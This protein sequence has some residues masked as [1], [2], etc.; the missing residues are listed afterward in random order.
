MRH[1][2]DLFPSTTPK[3]GWCSCAL[4]CRRT[5]RRYY[6][7]LALGIGDE[8]RSKAGNRAGQSAR[9]QLP[10]F[11][12]C[13][14]SGRVLFG[15]YD[16]AEGRDP[17]QNWMYRRALGIGFP[18]DR[19]QADGEAPSCRASRN[20]APTGW[21]SATSGG[22]WG[23][24]AA[25]RLHRRGPD[26]AGIDPLVFRGIDIARSLWPDENCGCHADAVIVQAG[27]VG[28]AVHGARSR[29][30]RRAKS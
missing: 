26:R 5:G 24:T 11:W 17:F 16:R 20:Q 28:K 9:M 12:R 18:H 27:S 4:P 13:R 6:I 22:C 29:S 14:G 7:S 19:L 21:C 10:R 25:A 1:A 8:F 30:R 2:N 23:S 3:S 15:H